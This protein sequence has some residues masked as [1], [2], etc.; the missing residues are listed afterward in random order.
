MMTALFP[1]LQLCRLPTVFTA[2]ADVF[3][4]YLLVH[5]SLSSDGDASAWDFA[6]LLGATCGLYLAGMVFNDVFD[7]HVDA[8]ERPGRPIPSGR[9]SVRAAVV[10][11][12]VLMLVGLTCAA[13][14]GRNTL[15]VAGL[16][17]A[18]ILGYDGGLKRT[19]LGPVVMGSCRFLNIIMAAS[20]DW[21]RFEQ[22][23]WRPQ[24]WVA[25]GMGVYIAGVTWFAR[26]EAVRSSRVQLALATGVVNLGLAVLLGWVA[27]WPTRQPAAVL[28]VLG[29]IMLTINRRLIAAVFDPAPQRVQSAIKTALLSIIMLDATLVF[30]KLGT[31][32]T[33]YAIAVAALV[34]PALVLGRWM[35]VT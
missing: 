12:A 11:G 26:T 35:R 31:E 25:A 21:L 23:W 14:V 27:Q 32:G 1:F 10:F 7:R 6:L 34:V 28:F 24:L 4:G 22:L 19:P 5:S 9:I 33:I 18:C 15:I 8:T 30:A 3:L 17:T 20:S 16:L 2:M 13:I 29:V